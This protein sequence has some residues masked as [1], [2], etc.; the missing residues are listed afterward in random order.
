MSGTS[1]IFCL[2]RIF[3]DLYIAS[4]IADQSL[5]MIILLKDLVA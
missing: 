3:A 2:S 5:Q 1:A 4:L